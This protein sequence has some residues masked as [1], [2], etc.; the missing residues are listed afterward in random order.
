VPLLA[1]IGV[2]AAATADKHGRA[3]YEYK[4]TGLDYQA[5][6][7]LVGGITQA[8]G[9]CS[10]GDASWVGQVMTGNADLS[11]LGSL[12]DGALEIGRR[13]TEGGI[14]AEQAMSSTLS[15]SEHTEVTECN[16]DGLHPGQM[17]D[18]RTTDC[19][20]TIPSDIAVSA[21]ISG[22]VGDRVVI[23]W[24]FF[25]Q[26]PGGFLLPDAFD[27][28]EHFFFDADPCKTR[29]RLAQFTKK[30]F[31]LPFKCQGLQAQPLGATNYTLF[32]SDAYANGVVSVKRAKQR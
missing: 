21:Q 3:S 15:G 1:L 10:V 24:N 19:G 9:D 23:D 7:A 2:P 30:K 31:S 11:K 29:A 16:G 5:T 22:G 12:G 4:V 8:P 25:H 20:E 13:G 26:G 32:S 17:T 18:Y 6:G 28:V 27:C 14:N